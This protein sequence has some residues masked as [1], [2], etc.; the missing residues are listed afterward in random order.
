MIINDK[1]YFT[2][3]RSNKRNDIFSNN[4]NDD[5]SPLPQFGH[6]LNSKNKNDHL[7]R[8]LT[9]KERQLRKNRLLKF[10][11]EQNDDKEKEDRDQGD[12]DSDNDD[13]HEIDGP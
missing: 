2:G 8:S 7:A 6:H 12:S 11:K 13:V 1:A 5:S 4:D 9:K 10:L 3:R